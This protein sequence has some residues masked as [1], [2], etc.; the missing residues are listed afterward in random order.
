MTIRYED[1][2]KRIKNARKERG[3]SQEKLAEAVEVGTT[4]ISHI[5]GGKT[6]PSLKVIV[7]IMNYLDLSPNYLFCGTVDT[8]KSTL[9]EESA[10]IFEECSP[11]QTRKLV[12]ALNALKKIEMEE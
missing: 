10:K 11:E 3:L 4:H 5:E 1:I 7:N 6:I 2:G 12:K 9:L 8:A